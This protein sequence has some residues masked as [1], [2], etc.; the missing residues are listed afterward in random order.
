LV[1]ITAWVTIRKLDFGAGLASR[2]ESLIKAFMI[3]F[4]YA[5]TIR[6]SNYDLIPENS[7]NP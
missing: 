5:A 4:L 6:L 3:S 7:Y 2:Y 1:Q